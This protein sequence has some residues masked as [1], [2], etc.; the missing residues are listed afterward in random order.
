MQNK[1]HEYLEEMSSSVIDLTQ[2][3]NE[4][5]ASLEISDFANLEEYNARVEEIQQKYLAQIERR[6]SE[7]DKAITNNQDLYEKDWK[8]YSEMT[9][10][11]ISSD[12]EWIDSFKETT[13]GYLTESESVFSDFGTRITEYAATLAETLSGAAGSYFSQIEEALNAYDTSIAGFGTHITTTYKSIQDASDTTAKKTTEMA[14]QMKDAFNEVVTTVG[15]WQDTEGLEI[16]EMLDEIATYLKDIF[17][18]INKSANIKTDA[19]GPTIGQE[20]ATRLLSDGFEYNGEHYD[21]G[22]WTF[23]KRG[24]LNINDGTFNKEG[25]NL[26]D[27]HAYLATQVQEA[28]DAY[29]S[30]PD[31]EMLKAAAE[32][33]IKK[34]WAYRSIIDRVYDPGEIEEP[35]VPTGLATGGYTGEWGDEGKL[36]ILHE[37]ELVL[38]ASDTANFLEA[39]NISRDVIHSMIEMNARASSLGLGDMVASSIKDNTQTIEQTVHITAEFPEATDRN[40]IEAAF[41]N[42]INMASQYAFRSE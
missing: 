30:D 42:L 6:E 33:L 4:E 9:G 14:T 12:K 27:Y 15:T 11:K 31:D 10:Y 37:K 40:E 19:G 13:L 8:A 17:D 20:E 5:I 21:F 38:S 29:Y 26:V 23:N 34:Y 7:L 1:N 24:D 22:T 25:S 16:T 32:A 39:L 3:M 41:D 28:L 36:A 18:A 35:G 2:Q